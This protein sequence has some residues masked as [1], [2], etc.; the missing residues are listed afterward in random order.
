[1]HKLYITAPNLLEEAEALAGIT[2]CF[3][4]CNDIPKEDIFLRLGEDG[5]AVITP[6]FKPLYIGDIYNKVHLRKNNLAKELLINAIKVKPNSEIL[7]IDATAGLG[8]DSVLLGL[9]GYRVLMFERNPFLATII[10]YAMNNKIIPSDNLKLIFTN[11]LDYF[12]ANSNIAPYAIYLD[13]M[14]KKQEKSLAKKDMQIIQLLTKDD[15]NVDAELFKLA[16]PL[17]NKLIIK[18]DSKQ[19]ALVTTPLPT[20]SKQGKTIRYDVYVNNI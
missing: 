3:T 10:Y 20:Y 14:F 15:K 18:R 17:C 12:K 16:Y 19:S 4:I 7:I 9:Y 11:S 2:N 13:P 8:K 6:H 5:L 1:M